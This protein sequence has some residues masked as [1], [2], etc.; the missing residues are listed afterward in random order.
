MKSAVNPYVA[1]GITIGALPGVWTWVS[2][3]LGMLT[4]VAFLT[5]ALFFAAGDWLPVAVALV[6]GALLG[7]AS[8]AL[9]GLLTCPRAA[10]VT[11]GAL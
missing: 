9:A 3:S 7:W 8:E 4:W 11:A 2:I 6:I 10:R 1:V 5:W